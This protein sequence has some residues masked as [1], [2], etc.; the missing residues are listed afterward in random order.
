MGGFGRLY[1]EEEAAYAAKLVSENQDLLATSSSDR[2]TKV[3]ACE[4]LH[5]LVLFS[6]GCSTQQ[7]GAQVHRASMAPL[8]KRIFP[9]MLKLS[10]DVEL[11][12]RQLFEPLMMQVIHW[13]TGNKQHKSE[14]TETLLDAIYIGINSDNPVTHIDFC[15]VF[16]DRDNPV[17]RIDFCS[18]FSVG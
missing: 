15:F 3:A 9:A 16:S 13:Y 14:E 5:S 11:V 4:L 2:Q 18:V 10:C 17:T 7:S 8:F 1:G 12:A 6:I